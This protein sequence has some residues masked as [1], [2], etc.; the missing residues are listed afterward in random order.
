M[1]STPTLRRQV[2]AEEMLPLLKRDAIQGFTQRRT[3]Q[4][5]VAARVSASVISSQ[6]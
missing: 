6:G 3:R 4:H 1:E 2:H 5:D